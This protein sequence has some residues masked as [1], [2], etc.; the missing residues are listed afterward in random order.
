MTFNKNSLDFLCR[1]NSLNYHSETPLVIIYVTNSFL[2][3]SIHPPFIKID[4]KPKSIL[5]TVC[6]SEDSLLHEALLWEWER[7]VTAGVGL[8]PE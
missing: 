7:Q 3:S 1:F 5:L 6:P 2:V 4:T 8:F